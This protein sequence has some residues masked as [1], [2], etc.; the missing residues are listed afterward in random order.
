MEVME[1][2]KNPGKIHDIV[3]LLNRARKLGW[4]ISFETDEGLLPMGEPRLEDAQKAY[5]GAG[6]LLGMVRNLLDPKGTKL[7]PLTLIE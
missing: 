4:A 3:D 5:E 6:K 2:G 7:W 1:K